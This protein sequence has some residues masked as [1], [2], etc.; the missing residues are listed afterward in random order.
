MKN[1]IPQPLIQKDGSGRITLSDFKD[2]ICSLKHWQ[3]VFRNY[4]P[5][6][7][8]V[9]KIEKFRDALRDVGFVIPERAL[10]LLVLKYMR[11]DGMLRFGDFVS[12]VVLL[13]RAFRELLLCKS[14]YCIKVFDL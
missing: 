11:K 10:S 9:L 3:V 12:A 8:S 2:L 14:N 1:I 4:A 7:M 6:K 5:E 13:H